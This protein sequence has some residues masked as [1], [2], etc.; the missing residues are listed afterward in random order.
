MGR[1]S[2]PPEQLLRA[3]LLQA[4]Y[5]I[6]SE[7]QLMERLHFDLL[8]RW[9]VG[10]GIDEPV[11]NDSTFSKNRDRLQAGDVAAEFPAQVL[12]QPRVRRL[13]S[14]E[15]FSVDSSLVE[16]WASMKSFRPKHDPGD[17]PSSGR[18]QEVGARQGN[19]DGIR[20]ATS[21]ANG[22]PPTAMLRSPIPM[23]GCTARV[24]ARK[25]SSA[26]SGTC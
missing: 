9:F 21:T 20:N 19:R 1:P 7:R 12:D 13:L 15:H 22:A 26:S 23:L 25:R 16:A 8:F 10:L 18:D 3:L 24:Q 5:S 14:S 4:F 17:P 6:R 2:I 11:W